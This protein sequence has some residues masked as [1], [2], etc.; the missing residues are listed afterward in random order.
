MDAVFGLLALALGAGFTLYGL[1]LL[2]FRAG[3]R[4]RGLWITL[5]SPVATIIALFLIINV[6]LPAPEGWPDRASYDAA[7]SEGI[8]DPDEWARISAERAEEARAKAE[9]EAEAKR[10]EEAA[11]IAAEEAAEAEKRRKGFHC[12]SAWDNSIRG[13]RDE[14][15]AQMREPDSFEHIQTRITPVSEAGTH[16][17]YMSYR[18]RNGFGGMNVGEAVAVIRN[19]DCSHTVVKAE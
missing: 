4:M 15:K 8:S 17:A 10:A 7:T 18:A 14:V 5:L 3:R 6:L 2:V 16:V 13:F 9:A 11:R 19:E 12:F 1:F